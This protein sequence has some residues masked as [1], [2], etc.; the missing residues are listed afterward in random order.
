MTA[1][2]QGPRGSGRR[3]SPGSLPPNQAGQAQ[4]VDL[5]P[6]QGC[7]FGESFFQESL[8]NG[9]PSPEP[10]TPETLPRERPPQKS[11]RQEPPE[12][13]IRALPSGVQLPWEIGLVALGPLPGPG[14]GPPKSL[15][16]LVVDGAGAIR[17]GQA[18]DSHRARSLLQASLTLAIEQPACGALPGRP[19]QVVVS[20]K[21][22]LRWLA[23]LL[24]PGSI[25][26]GPTP[27]L[28]AAMAALQ[29]DLQPQ[30]LA[31]APLATLCYLRE[32]VG[33]EA[34]AGCFAAAA[35]L[36]RRQPWD[37][38]PAENALFEFSAPALG[39]RR[40]VGCVIGQSRRN[41]GVI[42]F[43]SIDDYVRFSELADE[44]SS[45]PA[46]AGRRNRTIPSHRVISFEP[47]AAI[48]A[49][50][51]AEIK[52]H[53]WPVARGD[54]YPLLLQVG[55]D[56]E[57]GPLRRIDVQR[58]EAVARGLVQLI[59]ATPDLPSRWRGPELLRQRFRLVVAGQ[60]RVV[61]IG[62]VQE[63]WI[64]AGP[65]PQPQLQDPGQPARGTPGRLNPSR[66]NP[67]RRN[68]SSPSGQ[69]QPGSPGGECHQPPAAPTPGQAAG[70]QKPERVPAALR[71]KVDSLM[72]RI[73]GFC[74]ARLDREYRQLIHAAICALARKRPSPLLRGRDPSWA[75]GVV[76]AIGMANFL[77][78]KT[79]TP[80]CRAA[81]IC[82][83]F[84]VSAQ[85]AQAHSR[86]VCELLQI[87]PFSPRWTRPS[88]LDAT[89][90]AWMLEVNGLI[91]DIRSQPLDLQREACARGL[92]PYVPALRDAGGSGSPKC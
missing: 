88:R 92:I 72:E 2:P 38:F 46:G 7:L 57:L 74:E 33:P 10:L 36:Y 29:R 54:A 87:G 6:L 64:P 69:P 86:R 70:S 15:V 45:P 20:E 65:P 37:L 59:E 89:P 80:H 63:P 26:V 56:Q 31:D 61:S 85:T 48:P 24:P 73:D 79:Q 8:P 84:G 9:S 13:A 30:A 25:R 77:F 50:L 55:E 41:F 28:Q 67:G 82:A 91:V 52:R 43:D 68:P 1:P 12:P 19:S 53:R 58:L 76:Q 23:P 11:H 5:P 17:A 66:R 22:L 60:E 40:W 27:H 78:D 90:L 71:G 75:A 51:L 32:D 47:K 14:A 44:D 4:D 21:R 35:E 62:M 39:I 34:M 18:G 81:E 42:L 16:A 3:S 83:Y 49:S